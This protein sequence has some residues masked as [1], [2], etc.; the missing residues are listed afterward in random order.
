MECG[1][2]NWGDPNMDPE[3]DKQY[4]RDE[5]CPGAEFDLSHL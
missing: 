3:S 1:A 5:Y 2:V 4:H